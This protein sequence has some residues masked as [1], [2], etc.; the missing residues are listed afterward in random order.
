MMRSGST[1][2]KN[3]N[4]R[5]LG[6]IPL[7]WH[8]I[9]FLLNIENLKHI[10]IFTDYVLNEKQLQSQFS[11]KIV[12]IERTKIEA[13][14]RVTA[15]ESLGLVTN[16]YIKKYGN[17]DYGIYTQ[18]TEPFRPKNIAELVLSEF[19]KSDCDTA[20][21]AAISYKNYWTLDKD[22]VWTRMY[23]KS[24]ITAPRQEKVPLYREDSGIFLIS[25]ADVFMA[26]KRFGKNVLLVP[27]E[28]DSRIVDIHTK[29]D[30]K[31]ARSMLSSQ[32]VD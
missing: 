30:L 23:P 8:T 2:L 11:N 16:R 18:T 26:G 5:N 25:R 1:G 27:Y 14:N 10:V 31:V 15:D 29:I 20:C 9:R 21:A 28:E 7:Y 6:G 4:M 32:G 19:H 17:F 3:K 24:K 12:L 13:N 22:S